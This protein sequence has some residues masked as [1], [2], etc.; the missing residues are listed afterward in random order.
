MAQTTAACVLAEPDDSGKSD[1]NPWVLDGSWNAGMITLIVFVAL[2]AI[3]VA[4]VVGRR[5]RQ[6]D[7]M[8][9]K[10]LSK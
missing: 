7:D 3:I 5:I 10:L 4:V 1:S 6:R 9:T 2:A 8:D